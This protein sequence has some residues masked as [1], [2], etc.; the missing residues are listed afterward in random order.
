VVTGDGLI[1]YD[2]VVD[3]MALLG[4]EAGDWAALAVHSK[5][6]AAMRKERDNVGGAGLGRPLLVPNAFEGKLPTYMGLPVIVSDR[7]PVASGTP[8]LYTSLLLKKESLTFWMADI[9]DGDIATDRDIL[10]NSDIGAIH[11]YWAA[12][13]Y[14]RLNG[15]SKPG[16][17]RIVHS[18]EE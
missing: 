13:R 5:T 15:M 6:L 9:S 7:L 14:L 8:D 16:V 3:A 4:D 11:I 17:V 10:K 12:H 1:S 2:E 18:V